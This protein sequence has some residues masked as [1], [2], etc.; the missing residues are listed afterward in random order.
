[1]RLK[2]LLKKIL[3]CFVLLGGGSL[4]FGQVHPEFRSTE[5]G[6][7]IPLDAYKAKL[8][9]RWFQD[10]SL[11]WMVLQ[12]I[13]SLNSEF[14]SIYG[15]LLGQG[16]RTTHQNGRLSKMSV[17]LHERT[18]ASVS[19]LIFTAACE[20]PNSSP[21]GTS[22]TL[23]LKETL[24]PLAVPLCSLPFSANALESA[25]KL[26]AAVVGLEADALSQ[27]SFAQVLATCHRPDGT[28]CGPHPLQKV[29]Y[30]IL[31]NPNFI[32]KR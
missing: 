27:K 22:P 31:F 28:Q 24:K 23:H 30:W 9:S 11:C 2:S 15:Q 19:Q 16:S 18:A 8:C 4:A 26:Y 29:A 20:T 10:R 3:C 6:S 14:V 5:V 17:L 12:S 1:M 32:L 7:L 13:K 21:I 25:K